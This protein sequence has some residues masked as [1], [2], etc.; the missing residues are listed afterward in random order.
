MAAILDFRRR[1]YADLGEDDRAVVRAYLQG[2]SLRSVAEQFSTTRR[3]VETILSHS[4]VACREHQ[5]PPPKMTVCPVEG[6]DHATNPCSDEELLRLVRDLGP[7][8][9]ANLLMVD[10]KGLWVR[11]RKIMASIAAGRPE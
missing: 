9:T 3:R 2:F 1:K 7:E 8:Q 11:R 10:R 6:C 4:G 5:V